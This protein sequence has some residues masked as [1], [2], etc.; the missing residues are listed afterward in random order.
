MLKKRSLDEIN[1]I[2]FNV[3]TKKSIELQRSLHIYQALISNSHG[4]CNNN[5]EL[6]FLLISK[7]E[8]YILQ[9]I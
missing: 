3:N 8:D 5:V 4:Q 7:S 6:Y 2:C 1:V 9:I